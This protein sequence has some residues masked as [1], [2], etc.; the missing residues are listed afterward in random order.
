MEEKYPHAHE[1]SDMSVNITAN[2]NLKN[3]MLLWMG[4][5][6]ITAELPT[7][8]NSVLQKMTP[9]LEIS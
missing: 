4:A 3:G 2:T 5:R 9:E 1:I 6:V 7:V 8:Q